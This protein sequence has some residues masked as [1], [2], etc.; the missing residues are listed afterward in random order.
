MIGSTLM[1]VIG[2]LL[3]LLVV[4]DAIRTTLSVSSSGPLT[5]RL[6]SGLWFMLLGIHRR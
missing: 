4:Y 1:G 2:T 5:N 3:I 6:V